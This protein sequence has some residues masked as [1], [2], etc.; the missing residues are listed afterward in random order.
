MWNFIVTVFNT[1]IFEPLLNLLAAVLH[2]VPGNSMGLAIIIVIVLVRLALYLPSDKSLKTQRKLSELRPHLQELSKKHKG[3]S[4][5]RAKAQMELYKAHG[6]NPL[7][8]MFFPLFVQLPIFFGLYRVFLTEFNG[9]GF[10]PYLYS[11]IPNPSEIEMVFLGADLTTPSIAFALAAGLAQ[12]IQARSLVRHTSKSKTPKTKGEPDFQASMN[13]SMMYVLPV[14]V[15][16]F[17][18]TLPAGLSLYWVVSSL[19]SFGQQYIIQKGQ[20]NEGSK[21]EVRE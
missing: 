10:G 3:N 19:F 7:G 20:K 1:I 4:Q 13:M 21:I 12:F 6:V 18:L 5:E 14:M 2:V 11:F 17:G 16:G 15:V 9:N 8:S